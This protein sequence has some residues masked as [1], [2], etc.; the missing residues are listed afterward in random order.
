MR[1]AIESNIL[2]LSVLTALLAGVQTVWEHSNTS[3][4]AHH[5][6]SIYFW[7]ELVILSGILLTG[8]KGWT[9]WIILFGLFCFEVVTFL[10]N[11]M[12]FRPDHILMLVIV[13][14]RL[15]I[16]AKAAAHLRKTGIVRST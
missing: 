11:E 2:R 4:F 10:K 1:R 8:L 6:F 16:L 12:P 9:S 3:N 15:I 13:G 7:I 5:F 14:I